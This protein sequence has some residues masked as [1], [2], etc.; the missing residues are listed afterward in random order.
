VVDFGKFKVF[1]NQKQKNILTDYVNII[2]NPEMLR[3]AVVMSE[4][5]KRK[6]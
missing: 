6:F 1:E 4:I 3:Q 2:R 5:L